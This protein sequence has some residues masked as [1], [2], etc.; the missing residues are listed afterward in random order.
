MAVL[1]QFKCPCCDGAIEF[2]SQSQNMKCPYCDTEF[3]M[4]TL[5]AYD[6][7]LQADKEENMQWDSAAG[8]SWEQAE[9]EKM[10]VYA[11]QSCG[12]QIMA[13]DT[14]AATHCPYCGN[15]V[16]LMDSACS[17]TSTAAK[18]PIRP[19]AVKYPVMTPHKQLMGKK[20]A[21]SRNADAVWGSPIHTEARAGAKI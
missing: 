19:A 5:R 9:A 20:A 7:V 4:E 16:V 6:A 3:E 18:V 10:R 17:A 15:A 13:D 1:Q 11:C 12:G 8:G 21:N 2:D 14:T